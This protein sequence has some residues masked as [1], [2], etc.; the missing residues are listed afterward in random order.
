METYL[1]QH[2]QSRETD[3]RWRLEVSDQR[4]VVADRDKKEEDLRND[5]RDRS[6]G[7]KL[8]DG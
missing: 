2:D 4:W 7:K 8:D 3:Y 1:R 6:A 5:Y